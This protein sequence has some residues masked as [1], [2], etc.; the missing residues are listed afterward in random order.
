MANY[1]A[2]EPQFWGKDDNRGMTAAAFLT[3]FESLAAAGNWTP[4]DQ[5]KHFKT[6]LKGTAATWGT[7]KVPF[8]HGVVDINRMKELFKKEYYV[9]NHTADISSDWA[10]IKQ[11][12]GED[13]GSF[14]NR[15]SLALYDHLTLCEKVGATPEELATAAGLNP[16]FAELT[17][18]QQRTHQGGIRDLLVAKENDAL[19]RLHQV[20]AATI[21][22]T[23][24]LNPKLRELV[25]AEQRKNTSLADIFQLTIEADRNMGG[26][27]RQQQQAP[28]NGNRGNGNGRG[29]GGGHGNGNN[30][31]HVHAA[32][33][34][35]EEYNEATDSS[36]VHATYTAR[37]RGRGRGRG[38]RG[39][40][41]ANTRP[42]N[43]GKTEPPS[44]CKYCQGPHWNNECPTRDKRSMAA[45]SSQA[46]TDDS[47]VAYVDNMPYPNA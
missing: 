1:V 41:A 33:E 19:T 30:K 6:F 45:N 46:T 31:G 43:Q 2:A 37:G 22:A 26:Q 8:T 28:A 9:F 17:Q 34:V 5:L 47:A 15:V 32:E 13:I 3:R 11:R 16:N 21:Y 39:R 4:A 14:Q 42:Q 29:N 27:H 23:G 12:P 24:L 25:R 18:A 20:L 38:G 7:H 10:N 36:E 44:K 35:V 40:G